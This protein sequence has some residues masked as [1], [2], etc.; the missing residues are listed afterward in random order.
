ML[1]SIRTCLPRM[2][3]LSPFSCRVCCTVNIVYIYTVWEQSSTCVVSMCP[4]LA[5]FVCLC[6]TLLHAGQFWNIPVAVSSYQL[7]SSANA[8]QRQA[9][10]QHIPYVVTI[11]Y[12]GVHTRS[13]TAY[14]YRRTWDKTASPCLYGGNSQGGPWSELPGPNDPLIEGSYKDY[15]TQSLFD[16]NYGFSRFR[17]ACLSWPAAEARLSTSC[18]IAL[19]QL[20]VYKDILN[21]NFSMQHTQSSFSVHYNNQ[22]TV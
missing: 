10:N 8:R 1:Q 6:T 11:A 7:P 21:L 5:Y 15:I 13:F 18:C 16:V 9:F 4:I 3:C 12:P 2:H 17:D 20:R 19:Y 14:L 22:F